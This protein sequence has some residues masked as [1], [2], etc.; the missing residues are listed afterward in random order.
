MLASG[1]TAHELRHTVASL[2]PSAGANVK[3]AQRMLDTP[4][5]R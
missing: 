3:A 1:L 4:A 5:R 2:A